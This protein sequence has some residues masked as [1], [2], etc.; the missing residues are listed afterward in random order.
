M[1]KFK[2]AAAC[3]AIPGVTDMQKF[4]AKRMYDNQVEK[5]LDQWKRLLVKDE[6]CE[7]PPE[8]EV[9]VEAVVPPAAPVVDAAPKVAE[10]K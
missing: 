6:I 7:F 5:T 2:I 3:E 9:K 1:D 4:V 8:T 10:K